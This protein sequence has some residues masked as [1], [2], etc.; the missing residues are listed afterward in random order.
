LDIVALVLWTL[1]GAVGVVLLGKV[2]EAARRAAAPTDIQRTP[3][4]EAAAKEPPAS[5]VPPPIPRVKVSAA[6]GEHPLLEFSHPLVAFIGLACWFAFAFVHFQTFASIG[7]VA[8]VI[9]IAIGIYL[10]A[11]NSRDRTRG[12]RSA[13]LRLIMLHGL[14]AVMT[15]AL[16]AF[17]TLRA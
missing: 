8:L 7:L 3:V 15:L 13:P 9:T 6:P 4:P 11:M 2:S 12:V 16:A 10:L 1:T 5:R 14:A 17:I